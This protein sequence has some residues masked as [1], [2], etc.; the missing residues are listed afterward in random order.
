MF[1]TFTEKT[2]PIGELKVDFQKK[3]KKCLKK[4]I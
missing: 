2:F 3:K 4:M 1:T